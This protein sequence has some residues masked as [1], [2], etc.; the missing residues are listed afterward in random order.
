M[1]NGSLL[2]ERSILQGQ[3]YSYHRA[4]I[5]EGTARGV[6]RD[7]VQ[8]SQLRYAMHMYLNYQ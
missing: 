2:A 3:R 8:L 4:E 6:G 7:G 1:Q 5:R